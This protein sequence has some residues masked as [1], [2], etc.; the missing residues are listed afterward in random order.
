MGIF[1]DITCA[2]FPSGKEATESKDVKH[3][4]PFTLHGEK[5]DS[6]KP[7]KGFP[8]LQASNFTLDSFIGRF[9]EWFRVQIL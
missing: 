6:P 9:N 3:P 8:K 1:V 5:S 2:N 4:K 7:E